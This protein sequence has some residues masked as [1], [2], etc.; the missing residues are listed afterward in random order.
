MAI[1]LNPTPT[2]IAKTGIKQRALEDL[3]VI[4]IGEPAQSQ[5]DIRIDLA[6]NEVYEDLKVLGLATWG[7]NGY[8]PNGLVPH[9]V[10]LVAW[11]AV[12]SYGVSP[13]RYQRIQ[14]KAASAK[15]EIS[16]LTVP[17]HESLEEPRDF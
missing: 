13:A 16:L 5:D 6:Y 1:I 10:A 12:D 8:V 17:K 2:K 14:L 7:I 9:V 3:A 15:R 11:N 4:M